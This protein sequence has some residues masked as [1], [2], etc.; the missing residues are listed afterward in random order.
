VPQLVVLLQHTLS[1]QVPP[2]A[3]W[4]VVEHIAPRPS[5]ATHA[6]P[7]QKNPLA[8]SALLPQ[9]VRHVSEAVLHT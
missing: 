6:P 4:S 9:V 2:I 3:H 1:M 5:L 8:Q 7:L